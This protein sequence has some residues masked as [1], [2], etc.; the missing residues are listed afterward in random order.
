MR[1]WLNAD[2]AAAYLGLPTRN[3]LYERVRRG[4]VRAH[5]WGRSLRFRPEDLDDAVMGRTPLADAVASAL[6]PVC[7]KKGA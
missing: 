4:S 2:Q 3:A 5:R 7:R 1:G 6:T